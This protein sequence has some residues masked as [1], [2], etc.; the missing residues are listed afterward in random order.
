MKILVA[1]PCAGG[2]LY[3]NYAKSLV[4]ET[5]NNPQKLKLNQMALQ[6][7]KPQPYDVGWQTLFN[8]SL[9]SR[10]R[11][12]MAA[13]AL[14][15]D[16][17]KLFFID[18]DMLWKWDHFRKIVDSPHKGVVAGIAPL[19]SYP[20]LLNFVPYKADEKFFEPYDNVKCPEGLAEMHKHYIE[21]H[22]TPWVKVPFVGTAFM[23]IDREVLMKLAE[24]CDPYLYPDPITGQSENMWNMFVTKPVDN[25]FY[26]ED[27]GF[28]H[29]AREAGFDVHINTE[30]I[31]G[32][33]GRHVY[34]VT[35]DGMPLSGV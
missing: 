8:E 35:A 14:R 33:E 18:S 9:V 1:T 34:A 24:T 30:V 22:N 20:I 10:A 21:N 27:W 32:H 19:K 31:V 2:M 7:G 13:L 4:I 28:C 26:S 5:I 12:Y 3:G 6:K 15:Q 29:L 23:C 25:M 17:D 11:N 16:W